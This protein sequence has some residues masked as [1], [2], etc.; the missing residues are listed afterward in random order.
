MV[1]V[2]PDGAFS[3]RKIG[4]GWEGG[5]LFYPTQA[6]LNEKSDLF[7]TNRNNS[8]VQHFTQSE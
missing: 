5:F 2:S 4:M 7:I 3:G 8:R 6:C 1:L